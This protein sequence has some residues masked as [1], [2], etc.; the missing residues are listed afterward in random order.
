M[1]PSARTLSMWK[2]TTVMSRQATQEMTPLKMA[3]RQ[4]GEEAGKTGSVTLGRD[5]HAAR[6]APCQGQQSGAGPGCTQRGPL[7]AS[8]L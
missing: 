4:G 8:F 3:W 1:Q 5:Q 2:A 6:R 7:P